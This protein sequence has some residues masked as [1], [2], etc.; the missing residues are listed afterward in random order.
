MHI[1]DNIVL[2]ITGKLDEVGLCVGKN[3]EMKKRVA[4]GCESEIIKVI[5]NLLR[6]FMFGMC[7]AG[8]GGGGFIYGILRDASMRSEALSLLIGQ[9]VRLAFIGYDF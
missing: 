6:P 2:T 3:W 9:T 8:A 4:P 5:M 1:L 7:S